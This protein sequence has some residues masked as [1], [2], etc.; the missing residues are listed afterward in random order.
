MAECPVKLEGPVPSPDGRG[1]LWRIV[2]LGWVSRNRCKCKIFM[3]DKE[4]TGTGHYGPYHVTGWS[5]DGHIIIEPPSGDKGALRFEV[6]CSDCES[7]FNRTIGCPGHVS[8]SGESAGSATKENPD[9][10]WYLARQDALINAEDDSIAALKAKC[11]AG[12]AVWPDPLQWQEP[13]GPGQGATPVLPIPGAFT[14]TV[15]IK[16]TRTGNCKKF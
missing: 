12:C 1:E 11:K 8:A 13:P 3:N 14:Y 5:G 16:W 15:T 9:K 4:V 7:T 2:P 10:A 6:T